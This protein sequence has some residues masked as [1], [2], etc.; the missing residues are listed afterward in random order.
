[1]ITYRHIGH[2]LVIS[3]AIVYIHAIIE[4]YHTY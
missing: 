2:V 4:S 3:F 1:M